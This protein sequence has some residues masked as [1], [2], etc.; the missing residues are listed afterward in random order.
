MICAV[1]RDFRVSL[2]FL[3]YFIPGSQM[4]LSTVLALWKLNWKDKPYLHR[5][6][7]MQDEA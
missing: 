4:A 7:E 1:T 6:E 3:A 5:T 2:P